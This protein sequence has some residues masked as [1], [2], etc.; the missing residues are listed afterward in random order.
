RRRWHFRRQRC[1]GKNHRRCI[2]ATDLFQ[3]GLRGAADHAHYPEGA[4][5]TAGPRR[6]HRTWPSRRHGKM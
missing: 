1:L 3:H 5:Q 2:A 6:F 4:G